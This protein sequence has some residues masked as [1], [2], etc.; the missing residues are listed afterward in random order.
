VKRAIFVV[1]AFTASIC[2]TGYISQ[3]TVRGEQ[4]KGLNTHAE[5]STAA[6]EIRAFPPAAQKNDAEYTRAIIEADLLS[7]HVCQDSHKLFVNESP[8]DITTPTAAGEGLVD[9]EG[10]AECVV[11]LQSALREVP[12]THPS[13]SDIGTELEWWNARLLKVDPANYRRLNS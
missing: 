8:T 5:D 9:S 12:V 1:I 6:A 10:A 4:M 11:E 3:E 13:Y 2:I 7:L